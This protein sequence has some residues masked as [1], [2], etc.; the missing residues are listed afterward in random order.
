MPRRFRAPPAALVL[1][2]LAAAAT[3]TTP[4][5]ATSVS[6]IETS[7]AGAAAKVAGAVE[8][9]AKILTPPTMTTA[10]DFAYPPS[11]LTHAALKAGL[12]FKCGA[13]VGMC[14]PGHCCR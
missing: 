12:T 6:K 11:K 4:A 7:V 1:A 5:S 2:L 13:G 10:K 14:P 3:I 8:D 9:K